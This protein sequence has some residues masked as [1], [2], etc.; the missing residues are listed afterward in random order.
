M[1][2]TSQILAHVQQRSAHVP[3]GTCA[4]SL[5]NMRWPKRKNTLPRT[6]FFNIYFPHN[7]VLYGGNCA[8]IIIPTLFSGKF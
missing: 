6:N 5:G 1:H 7:N 3:W 4:C 2:V 8:K